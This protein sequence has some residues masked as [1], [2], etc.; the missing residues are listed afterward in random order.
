[1]YIF[2]LLF[3]APQGRSNLQFNLFNGC[4]T[5]HDTLVP[6]PCTCLTVSNVVTFV[7]FHQ[8]SSCPRFTMQ[9]ITKP[10]K[11]DCN[12]SF[13]LPFFFLRISMVSEPE[14]ELKMLSSLSAMMLSIQPSNSKWARCVGIYLNSGGASLSA[15]LWCN[16]RSP[17]TARLIVRPLCIP[18]WTISFCKVPF[19]ANSHQASS[20]SVNAFNRFWC[21]R[22]VWMSQV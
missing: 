3:T 6:M 20:V 2:S 13:Y 17:F 14:L 8:R 5:W 15:C 18:F 22:L 11:I 19:K 7:W 16:R 21:C 1:M 4:F 12:P 9:E 10:T